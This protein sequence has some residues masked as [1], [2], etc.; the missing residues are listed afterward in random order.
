MKAKHWIAVGVIAVVC[1]G[2]G[3]V[4]QQSKTALHPL[5]SI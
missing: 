5:A 1:W 3:A 4:Q 2:C